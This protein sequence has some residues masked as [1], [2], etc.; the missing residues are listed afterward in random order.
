[1]N[2]IPE[3]KDV[4][5]LDFEPLRENEIGKYRLALVLTNQ[6]Y[7]K[8]GFL[9]CSPIS[10][11]IR[12]TDLEVQIN[13]MESQ[14]VVVTNIVQTFKWKA[15]KPKFIKRVSDE[16]YNDVLRRLL[17]FLTGEVFK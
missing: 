2:Y 17:P 8:S 3:R 12:G 11:S 15:R 10:T 7:N 1:M 4:I 6:A 9:I 16:T 14:S 13:D 5:W